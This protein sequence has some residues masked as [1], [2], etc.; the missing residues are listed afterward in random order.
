M[1]KKAVIVDTNVLIA[2]NGRETHASVCCQI[3]CI[4]RLIKLLSS[5]I[6]LLDS[7]NDIFDEYK[8]YCDFSGCPGVGDMF[9]KEIFQN[10]ARPDKVLTV[11]IS[12]TGDQNA[13]VRYKE[14]PD[15]KE[16][17]GFDPS[18]QKFVAVG[19]AFGSKCTVVNAMDGKW[20]NYRQALWAHQLTL[21]QICHPT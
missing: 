3:R 1:P 11:P 8:R 6:L 4:E 21:E 7:L 19:I 9:F 13:S 16:L 2:A 14:F 10:Q 12:R 20:E 17:Q 15:K 18:D 5:E